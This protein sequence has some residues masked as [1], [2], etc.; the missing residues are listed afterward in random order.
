MF[1]SGSRG[2]GNKISSQRENL[3]G[4]KPELYL[5]FGGESAKSAKSI[6]I[7]NC[8]GPRIPIC[9]SWKNVNGSLRTFSHREDNHLLHLVSIQLIETKIKYY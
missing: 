7:K 2:G 6:Q 4:G 1:I 3:L 8:S 5:D 9:S